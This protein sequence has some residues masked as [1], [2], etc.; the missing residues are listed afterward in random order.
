MASAPIASPKAH[1]RA[2]S[3]A[4]VF[5]PERS[6][7]PAA[8][9]RR[10][11]AAPGAVAAAA[12]NRPAASMG[13]QLD[14]LWTGIQQ[15]MLELLTRGMAA[16][17]QRRAFDRLDFSMKQFAKVRRERAEE[18]RGAF[19]AEPDAEQLAVMLD[20]MDR[21]IDELVEDRFKKLAGA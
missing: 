2:R 10:R 9:Q 11:S 12:E 21:R 17:F 15:Q 16:P 1:R 14:L 20:K 6:E 5:A 3:N 18:P 7:E 13:E 19:P 4:G 8:R